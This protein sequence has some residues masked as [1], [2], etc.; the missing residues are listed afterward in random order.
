MRNKS[1]VLTAIVSLYLLAAC[2]DHA[3]FTQ[4][5]VAQSGVTFENTLTEHPDFNF[6]NYLYFYNGGGVAAGDVNNDGFEDLFFTSNQEGNKLYLN[7]GD[8]SFADVTESAGIEHQP[9]SW[10]TGVSM[11]D[12][13][14]DGWLDIY[15]SNVNYLSRKGKNQLYINKGNGTFEEKAEEFGLD[16]EGYSVQ[17]AFLD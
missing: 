13:N 12:I 10:S 16:F 17:A 7:N 11:A 15:V 1:A 6:I 9:E 5:P 4:L 2:S 8:F 14:G 3:R